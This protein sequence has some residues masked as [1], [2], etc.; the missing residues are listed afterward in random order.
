VPVGERRGREQLADLV[1]FG[2]RHVPTLAR[3]GG[4]PTGRGAGPRSCAATTDRHATG[5]RHSPQHHGL[6]TRPPD[7]GRMTSLVVAWYRARHLVRHGGRCECW[8]CSAVD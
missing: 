2:V 4:W 6:L 3:R 5:I 1:E 8:I 7:A